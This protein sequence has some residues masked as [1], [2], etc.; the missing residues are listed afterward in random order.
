MFSESGRKGFTLIEKIRVNFQC[1]QYNL[2]I[3]NN[4]L[5]NKFRSIRNYLTGIYIFA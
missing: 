2:I 3:N 1:Y 5:R 4:I